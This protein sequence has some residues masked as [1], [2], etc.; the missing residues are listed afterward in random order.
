MFI[1]GP[2]REGFKYI[3]FFVLEVC[4]V[5]AFSIL[6]TVKLLRNVKAEE[7]LITNDKKNQVFFFFYS[8][9]NLKKIDSSFLNLSL[10]AKTKRRKS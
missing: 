5:Y 4:T 6:F 8:D 9:L 1:H 10:N 7:F 3:K 2:G